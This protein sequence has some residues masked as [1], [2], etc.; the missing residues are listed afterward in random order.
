MWV[1]NRLSCSPLVDEDEG[2]AV[3]NVYM[4]MQHGT[5]LQMDSDTVYPVAPRGSQFLQTCPSQT[6]T[7]T[8]GPSGNSKPPWQVAC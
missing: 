4:H 5:L 7:H 8:N 2:L 3:G 1:E 6:Y